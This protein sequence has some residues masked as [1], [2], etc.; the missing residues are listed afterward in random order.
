MKIKIK[1]IRQ[2]IKEEISRSL[3]EVSG[4]AR[5]EAAAASL[6]DEPEAYE[7]LRD[8][9]AAMDFLDIFKNAVAP[10]IDDD[11][12]VGNEN[13]AALTACKS[14]GAKRGEVESIRSMLHMT[15]QMVAADLED[16]A[17]DMDH[18]LESDR[19]ATLYQKQ[20]DDESAVVNRLIKD[21]Q[22]LQG[23]ITL[24]NK[25]I[26]AKKSA[27]RAAASKAIT[28]YV[29]ESMTDADW[30]VTDAVKVHGKI[31]QMVQNSA[32]RQRG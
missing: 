24:L 31:A 22:F 13:D 27:E 12:A 11:E 23:F 25:K 3:N 8:S 20:R 14:Q 10:I 21:K 1:D 2:I 7:D 17:D 6:R 4:P 19:R 30:S 26:T 5:Y 16:T 15:A 29:D 9:Q 32:A 28:D 18:E